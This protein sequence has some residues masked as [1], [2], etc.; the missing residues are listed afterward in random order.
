MI[1]DTKSQQKRTFVP[2][3]PKKIG[4]Y[5]CGITVYDLCHIGHARTM[6]AFDVI[7]RYLKHK[8]GASNVRFVR[9]ITDIDDKII[10]RAIENKEEPIAL[11]ERF[12]HEMHND[13]EALSLL[14]P[15]EEPRATQYMP[16]M[17]NL[18]QRLVDKGYAYPAA[19]GDVYYKVRAYKDYGSLAKRSLD[20][21]QV[22]ARIE[23]NEAKYDPLDFVL[24]KAAKPGEPSWES[25]WGEGRPG[26]HLE[27]S[28]MSMDLLGETFDIHGGGFDLIFPHHEN[29]CAQSSAASGKEFANN[30]MHVGFLQIN[31]DKMS[32]SSGNFVTIQQ[33]LQE[34]TPEELR[35]F[36]L[37]GH[38]RSPLEYTLEQVQ[39]AK[40]PL[41]R[42]YTALHNVAPGAQAATD[43]EYTQRF[44]TAMDDDFN[45]PEALAVLFDL[46]REVNKTKDP[47]LAAQL[48]NLGGILG[49]LQNSPAQVL[50]SVNVNNLDSQIQ[51]L[52]TARN[53]ARQAKNW[54]E[55]DKIRDQLKGMG[56]TIDD[57]AGG[58][59]VKVGS[60]E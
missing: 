44:Y 17:L 22:G 5:V 6:L 23:A 46:A 36:V 21:L 8:Y 2:I 16:Q 42:L 24:W 60:K 55:A 45:T 35:Y 13:A 38:Y 25:P 31:K 41:L 14:T 11:A 59:Q 18:I 4:I 40:Q 39:N 48:Q 54:P 28:A 47:A 12:I 50:G 26:W 51:E 32:K 29:E 3:D 7:V 10:N 34:V 27:C 57:T 19:N 56:V 53:Q 58:S 1:Y 15:D 37:S 52:I 30:W 20:D 9:N 33:I 49:L 43:N